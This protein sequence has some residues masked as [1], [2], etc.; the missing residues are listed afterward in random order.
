MPDAKPKKYGM[1][2]DLRRC[3]GCMSCT[4]SCKMENGI[5]LGFFRSWVNMAEKGKFPEVRRY[6]QPRL[7]NHCEK[8]PCVRVCPVKA[9]YRREDGVVLIDRDRCIGCGYCVEACPYH[10]RFINPNTKVAEKCDFCRERMEKG[11]PPACVHNCMGKARIFGDLNDPQSDIA[12][13]LAVN[14][15]RQLKVELGT[16]PHVYYIGLDEFLVMVKEGA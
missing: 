15:A 1:V 14:P 12:R 5:P 6:F 7:C 3:V 8:A 9:S 11:L 4:I 13:L 16:M 2:I 10:A